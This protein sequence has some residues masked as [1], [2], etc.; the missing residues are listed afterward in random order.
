M[1]IDCPLDCEYLIESRAFERMPELD[2]A[3]IPN[4]DVRITDEFLGENQGL[5]VASGRMLFEAAARVPGVI[6]LDVREALEALIR[7][8]RTRETGLLYDTRP[9]NPLAGGVQAGFEELLR[10][11]REQRAQATGLH[12]IREAQMLGVLVFLERLERQ[13]NNGR[14]RGRAFLDF[15]RG[16]YPPPEAMEPQAVR[17]A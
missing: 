14:R 13:H 8:Y 10:R 15:L 1:S 6:D 5:I 16:W 17:P 4:Q 2:P 12:D 7:T 11:F 9:Q 3:T